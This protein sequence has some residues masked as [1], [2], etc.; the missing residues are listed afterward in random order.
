MSGVKWH[1]FLPVLL[2]G[3]GLMGPWGGSHAEEARP[4]ADDPAVEKRMLV[5]AEDM[6]CLVCQNESLAAS[7]ADLAKDLRREIRDQIRQGKTDQEVTDYMVA[8][9][10]DF[11]RYRP[12]VKPVTWALWFGPFVLL[13]G[14]VGLLG[15]VLRRRILQRSPEAPLSSAQKQ[16]IEALLRDQP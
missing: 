13:L 11:V 15:W 7:Q 8:R 14:A 16:Q 10:G 9:Y 6:R 4:L 3:V 1:K 12:P 5:I 2:L